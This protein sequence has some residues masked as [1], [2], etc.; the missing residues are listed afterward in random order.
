M[1]ARTPAVAGLFYDAD[2][3]RLRRHVDELLEAA[4]DGD[5]PSP[6][7]LIV[8]HAGYIYSGPTAARAYARLRHHPRPIHRVA[9]FG[10]AHRVHLEGMAVPSVEAFDTPL[11]R[12]TLDREGI[13]AV[14]SMPGVCVSDEAHREEHSLEVQLPFLQAVLSDFSLVPVVVGRCEPPLVGAVMEALWRDPG[15]L[16]VVSTDLSHFHSYDRA[17]TLD[18]WTCDK[19]LARDHDLVGEEACGAAALNGLMS[20]GRSRSLEM[21]LIDLCNSG[22]TAGDRNRVVGYGAFSLH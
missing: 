9:L 2:P 5:H 10:P 7:A 21:E 1:T 17:R 3:G 12:I 15:T 8:P 20:T 19:L 6:R 16:L 18:T 11:G 13:D 14:R 4:G 22:D